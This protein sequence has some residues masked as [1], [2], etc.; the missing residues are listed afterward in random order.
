[1]HLG[2]VCRPNNG[3]DAKVKTAYELS[4]LVPVS[5]PSEGE[6]LHS[7]LSYRR[8]F[9]YE[10]LNQKKKTG[11][12]GLFIMDSNSGEPS[13]LTRPQTFSNKSFEMNATCHFWVVK[14]GGKKVQ[15]N[16]TIRQCEGLFGQ[17]LSQLQELASQ[18]EEE[19]GTDSS[20]YLCLSP[21]SKCIVSGL[22]YVKDERA[23]L[24]G[25]N[26]VLQ[27]YLQA[28]N[29]P[30][31]L[32][33]N[34]TKPQPQFR[35]L[36]PSCNSFPFVPLPFPP[37]PAHSPSLSMLPALNW[38]PTAVQLCLEAYFHMGVHSYPKRVSS[39][40]FAQVPIGNLSTDEN[41]N[42]FDVLY[43]RSLNKSR[44]VLWASDMPSSPDLG[45]NAL[46]LVGQPGIGGFRPV[47]TDCNDNDIWSDDDALVSPVIMK[48]G[49][50][51][52]VCVELDIH[53]LC[54]AA[55]T[56]SSLAAPSAA[57]S[58][59][60]NAAIFESEAQAQTHMISSAAP[61]GDEMSTAIS[62]P[63]LRA[64]IQS[65]LREAYQTN[66]MTADDLL[67]D[68]YRLVS[69]PNAL[70][71][72]PALHRV[73]HSLMKTTFLRLLGELQRLGSTIISADFH[74]V[75]IATNK[76]NIHDAK[77]YIEFVIST[78]LRR[79]GG[80]AGANNAAEG[81]ARISL[82]PNN[83]YAHYLFLDQ[84]NFGAIHFEQ[85]EI[86]DEDENEMTQLFNATEG[87]KGL[88]IVPTVVCGWN[89]MH[90]LSDNLAQ[91][92]FRT[93]IG[94]FSKDIFRKQLMIEQ[95]EKSKMTSVSPMSV[96]LKDEDDE[97]AFLSPQEQ[98]IN[99][100]K[101]VISKHFA[102]YLTRV[103]GELL[104]DGEGAEK[105]PKLPGSYLHLTDPALEFVKN[106]LTV[107]NL[108]PDV[109]QEVIY[110]KKSLFAQ[111][112]VQEY[113]AVT[114]WKNP[115]ASFMLPDVYCSECHECRDVDLCVIPPDVEETASVSAFVRSQFIMLP[116]GF[117]ANHI[118]CTL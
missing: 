105:F 84:N 89:I 87:D 18:D 55:L 69:S 33:V 99:Y 40:R 115:A 118:Q 50:Y 57:V 112:G 106:V 21:D 114:Q 102:N 72:D 31:L 86:E 111:I 117:F 64:L 58:S 30:T 45:L 110:L 91:D 67:H 62:L 76:N 116:H 97:S 4:E 81:L 38:E 83:F 48:P 108:D 75:V 29:G 44:A 10:N 70:L 39:S 98:L 12:V 5:R 41:T 59:N 74:K 82:R 113:S 25:A 6:Y 85:R 95:K 32:L 92:Y 43:A 19:E 7:K 42:M 73:V 101:K 9:M 88:S 100:K 107:L 104:E 66:N 90:Y 65:W 2:S 3:R 47:E 61:L 51:R 93:I 1:M 53:D 103:V 52:C 16:V 35:K 78:I 71:N 37:G 24:T 80:D 77:E 11:L 20:E 17:L 8:I 96:A 79:A 27:A 23:A 46:N 49:A 15:K 14:P 60:Q 34:S 94:R 22:S 68:V 54:I 56:D 36:V 13:D 109:K 63:V 26:E 28:N